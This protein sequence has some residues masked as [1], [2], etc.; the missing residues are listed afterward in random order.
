MNR[1]SRSLAWLSLVVL[2]PLCAWGQPHNATLPSKQEDVWL[3]IPAYFVDA[4]AKE[5]ADF[6]P[7]PLPFEPKQTTVVSKSDSKDGQSKPAPAPLLQ[8]LGKRYP[9]FRIINHSSSTT[10]LD[11]T[12]RRYFEFG[13]VHFESPSEATCKVSWSVRSPKE[14]QFITANGTLTLTRSTA[15]DARWHV[16]KWRCEQL[17]VA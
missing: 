12:L 10:S 16:A 7:H 2:L 13:P 8:A 9:S 5:L 6:T 14:A 4:N 1:L 11:S 3:A 17:T 15:K